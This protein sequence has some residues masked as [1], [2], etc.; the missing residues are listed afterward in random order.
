MS[1]SWECLCGTYSLRKNEWP[2]YLR[3]PSLYPSLDKQEPRRPDSM[4]T[5]S[6]QILSILF[7]IICTTGTRYFCNWRKWRKDRYPAIKLWFIYIEHTLHTRMHAHSHT[8]TYL[9]IYYRSYNAYLVEASEECVEKIIQLTVAEQEFKLW[10]ECSQ[11][12][13]L[14]QPPVY[15]QYRDLKCL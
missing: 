3:W 12:S 2:I 11:S 10:C 4:S 5:N 15:P 9:T 1:C 7:C 14:K 13:H 6:L 8:H